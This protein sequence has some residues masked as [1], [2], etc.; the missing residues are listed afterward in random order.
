MEKDRNLLKQCKRVGEYF[1]KND[2]DDYEIYASSTIENDIEVFE[3]KVD[4]LSFSDSKGV[5]IRVYKNNAIGYAYTSLMDEKN[6]LECID[7]AIENTKITSKEEL[8][9]LPGKD[10]FLYPKKLISGKSLFSQEYFNIKPE[11]KTSA[12]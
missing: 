11:D 8:N 2:V 10:E 7:S 5:G 1:E 3:N 12:T 4:S 6:I 9:S